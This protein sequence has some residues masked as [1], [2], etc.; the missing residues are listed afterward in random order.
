MERVA[1]KVAFITGGARGLAA[2]HARLL[3][4]EG[5]SVVLADVLDADGKALA[6]ELGD[7]ASILR[8]VSTSLV[9]TPDGTGVLS[10]AVLMAAHFARF[11]EVAG[12]ALRTRVPAVAGS[13]PARPLGTVMLVCAPGCDSVTVGE[14][15]AAA[16]AA[17]NRVA[18]SLPGVPDQLMRLLFELLYGVVAAGQFSV[19]TPEC[20]WAISST[21]LSIVVLTPSRAYLNDRP[22]IAQP[23]LPGQL[24][25]SIDLMRFYS[26]PIAA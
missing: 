14:N 1:G 3:V 19:L 8:R 18:I 13:G 15:L 25:S 10:G 2:A 26:M 22:W 16:L 11:A 17:G 9:V 12:S 21:D 7:V 6:V 23:Q 24:T 4:A 20:G 5:A